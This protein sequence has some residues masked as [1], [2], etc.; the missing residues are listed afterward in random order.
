MYLHDH[1]QMQTSGPGILTGL[2]ETV[3]AWIT[4]GTQSPMVDL[5][6]SSMALAV[7]SRTQHYPPAATEAS[8]RYSRLLRLV[9]ERVAQLAGPTLDE[10]NVD[11]CLLTVTLMGRFESTRHKI[12]RDQA[13]GS[14]KWLQSWSHHDGAMAILKFWHDNPNRGAASMVIKQTRRGLIRSFLLRNF[15]LPDW[16]LDGESF[17]EQG[18]ENDFDRV[19]V[20]LVNLHHVLACLQ[21]RPS[22][23]GNKEIEKLDSEARRLDSALQHCASQLPLDFHPKEHVLIGAGPWPRRSFYSSVV[24]MHRDLATAAAWSQYYAMRMLI[25]SM[26]LKMLGFIYPEVAIAFKCEFR[27]LDCLSLLDEMADMLS[28]GMPYC[29]GRVKVDKQSS[30]HDLPTVTSNI[31]EDIKPYLAGMVVWPLTIASSLDQLDGE[32]QKWFRSELASLGRVTGD[33]IIEHA[34]TE[35]WISL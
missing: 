25:N 28:Y 22:L 3:S 16:L 11:A 29:L 7:F 24:N 14:F 8:I 35:Q 9:Q 1:L 30:D 33:S 5:A 19:F 15:L 17:G 27:R 13:Q 21:H 2:A 4:S 12:D 31:D 10:H 18:I 32:R 20:R 34:E 6:L 26:R 23:E